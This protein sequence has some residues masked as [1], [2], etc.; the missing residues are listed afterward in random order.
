MVFV[1]LNLFQNLERHYMLTHICERIGNS[2][3]SLL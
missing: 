3:Q 2:V 1:I